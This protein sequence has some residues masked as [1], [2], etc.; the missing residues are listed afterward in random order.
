M[1]HYDLEKRRWVD[2]PMPTGHLQGGIT[3]GRL[4][5]ELRRSGEFK[6]NERVTRV[7]V[8]ENGLAYQLETD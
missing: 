8:T 7:E 5:E 4:V 3:W 1:S 6:A 2:G